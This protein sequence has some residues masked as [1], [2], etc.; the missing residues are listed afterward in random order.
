MENQLQTATRPT[1]PDTSQRNLREWIAT[2]SQ[3]GLAFVALLYV[4]GFIIVQLSMLRYGYV[5][6]GEFRTRYLAAGV[7]WLF[8]TGIAAVPS[9][10]FESRQWHDY[11]AEVSTHVVGPLVMMA[12]LAAGLICFATWQILGQ[13]D[14]YPGPH[15]LKG[16]TCLPSRGGYI[17]ICDGQSAVPGVGQG[18]PCLR[19]VWPSHRRYA[20]D[21]PVNIRLRP[22]RLG[23]W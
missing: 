7:L 21:L 14:L 1:G 4:I 23:R 19:R 9:L 10:Y 22:R 6:V 8:I 5:G 18:D 16:V 15:Y 12:A 20:A 2:I 3:A 13:R 11:Q 17:V